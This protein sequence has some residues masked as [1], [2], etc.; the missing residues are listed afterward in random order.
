MPRDALG[1]IGDYELLEVVGRGGM[2]QVY[3]AR[4]KK[5]GTL[6]ALKVLIGPS[7]LDDTIGA[8]FRREAEVI[9]TITHPSVVRL[10][11]FGTT[12]DRRNYLVM[13]WV[14]GRALSDAITREAPFAPARAADIARKIAGGLGAIHAH[15]FVHRDLKP[16]NILLTGREEES[17]KIVDFGLVTGDVQMWERLTRTGEIV[18]TPLYMA[19]ESI[20]G[21]PVDA[22]TDLYS[23]GIIIYEMLTG[24]VPFSS[25]SI[26]EILDRHLSAKPPRL[27]PAGGIEN[28]ALALLEKN[29]AMRFIDS[30][31]VITALDALELATRPGLDLET[32]PGTPSPNRPQAGSQTA[33]GPLTQPFPIQTWHGAAVRSGGSMADPHATEDGDSD[34]SAGESAPDE[35]IRIPLGRTDTEFEDSE[36]TAAFANDPT[37]ALTYPPPAPPQRPR[38]DPIERTASY[39]ALGAPPRAPEPSTS[40]KITVTPVLSAT[41]P[42]VSVTPAVSVTAAPAISVTPAHSAGPQVTVTPVVSVTPAHAASPAVLITPSAQQPRAAQPSVPRDPRRATRKNSRKIWMRVLFFALGALATVLVVRWVSERPLVIEIQPEPARPR[43][44]SRETETTP[45]GDSR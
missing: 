3:R 29:P 23:L 5:S 25:P 7:A 27:R 40:P 24:D 22:R 18:G 20:D 15:D 14:E 6:C 13:E 21:R 28:V 9:Q 16:Q 38:V 35:T 31:A 10:L 42:H 36:D 26:P 1:A 8:R 37:F 17:L 30:A 45:S 33:E 39:E 12:P 19:P 34:D 41:A 11:D 4:H 43:A 2:A 32:N 44:V